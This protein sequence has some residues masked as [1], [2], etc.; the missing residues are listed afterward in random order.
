MNESSNTIASAFSWKLIEKF[1]SK[2]VQFFIQI[3]LARIL[4]P[5]DYGK[6]TILAVFITLSNVLI[7]NGFT[8]SLIQ[9]KD[10]DDIDF[11]TAF[12]FSIGISALAY[13]ILFISAPFIADFYKTDI[14]SNLLRV[15]AVVLFSGAVN[16]VQYA[17][18]SRKL[19]FKHYSISTVISSL[20]SGIFGII[21]AYQGF[22]VWSLVLQQLIANF[23]CTVLLWFM[24]KWRPLFIFSVDRIKGLFSYGWKILCTSLINSLYANIYSLVIGKTYNNTMLGYYN[25]GDQFPNLIVNNIND[26]IQSIM[27]PVLSK[28]QDNLYEVKSIM[29]KGLILSTFMIF[30][31]MLGL[32]SVSKPLIILVLTEKWL[33]VVPYLWL[34]C[35]VYMLYPIHTAN[36]QTLKALGRSDLFLKLEIVKKTIEI[37]VLLLTVKHGI[38]TMIAGQMIAS[39]IEIF[40]NSYPL[41]KLINYGIIQQLKDIFPVVLSSLGMFFVSSLLGYLNIGVAIK[42]LIQVSAGIL[43]YVIINILIKSEALIWCIQQIKRLKT[44]R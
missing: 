1:G 32:M 17:Y 19:M 33:P 22:G 35:I 12:Y 41:K 37:T 9:K 38:M 15:L 40:I 39:F 7:Q 3:V 8:T 10:A 6:V 11:S 28:A 30:P 42:F 29:R 43:V 36:I 25:R 20:I 24:V 4:L 18:I 14:L 16:S 21:L 34:L 2:G 27:L 26:A 5:E 23:L 31:M 44:N 13:T